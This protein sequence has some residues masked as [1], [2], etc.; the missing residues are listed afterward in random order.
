M[1]P[2]LPFNPTDL[3]LQIWAEAG[4][5]LGVLVDSAPPG[6]K[7]LVIGLMALRI[8]FP[9]FFRGEP[10]RRSRRRRDRDHW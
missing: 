2:T 8:V 3:L 10:R 1:S 6:L 4:H 9:S 7:L 5:F